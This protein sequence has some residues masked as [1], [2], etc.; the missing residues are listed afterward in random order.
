MR[1][2]LKQVIALENNGLLSSLGRSYAS[3]PA[4]APAND[5]INVTVD[6]RT[7]QVPKGVSVIQACEAAGVDIPRF[8][9]SNFSLPGASVS[10]QG[11][12][13]YEHF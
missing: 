2:S 5:L 8:V 4:P 9:C 13:E 3:V 1:K 11:A 10:F 12:V 6:G 7:V